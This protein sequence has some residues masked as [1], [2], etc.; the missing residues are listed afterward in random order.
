MLTTP[1]LN[2]TPVNLICAKSASNLIDILGWLAQPENP[3]EGNNWR[4]ST[5]PK[6][7]LLAI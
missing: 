3:L 7:I 6:M 4:S 5:E 2:W 1:F